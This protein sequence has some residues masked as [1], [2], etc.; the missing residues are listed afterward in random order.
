MK[1]MK[2]VTLIYIPGLFDRIGWLQ[3]L[4][5]QAIAT[6]RA[7]GVSPQVFVMGWSTDAD[8][9]QRLA[10]L[11]E[12]VDAAL[13]RDSKVV[14]VGASAGASAVLALLAKSPEKISAA[15]SICGKIHRPQSIPEPVLEF[16]SVF[17]QALD[18]LPLRLEQLTSEELGRTLALHAYKDGIVPTEDSVIAGAHNR[19]IP[20]VGHVPGIATALIGLAPQ[21]TTFCRR[22]A[23][24]LQTPPKPR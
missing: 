2:R 11:E 17:D 22:H 20:A 23:A 12:L 6:W 7:L 19:N 4:Q 1:Q 21:I 14:L 18:Q 5:R 16:N 15:V 10:E 9:T 24:K 3:F 8:F 13:A